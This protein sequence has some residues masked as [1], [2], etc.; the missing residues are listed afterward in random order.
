MVLYGADVSA[1]GVQPE[2]LRE[3]LA[4]MALIGSPFQFQGRQYYLPGER[5]LEL[6]VFLGCSPVIELERQD[7]AGGDPRMDAFCHIHLPDPSPQPEFELG[8]AAAAPRCPHCRASIQEWK[9]L[10]PQWQA[11]PVDEL[12]QCPA[13]DRPASAARINW[14]QAAA[15]RRSRV[16]LGGIHPYEAVPA[17]ELLAGLEQT[18]SQ[19]WKYYYARP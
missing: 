10:L 4:A 17:D 5:F 3:R 2:T 9:H 14:R 19:R 12:W 7:D 13:C 18:G 6:V 16:E 11:Q 15:V 1:P 8:D